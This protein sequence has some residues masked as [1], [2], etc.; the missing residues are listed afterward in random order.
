[1][2]SGSLDVQPHCGSRRSRIRHMIG[3]G[4]APLLARKFC[5][6]KDILPDWAFGLLRS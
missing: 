6:G 3:F 5:M 2:S 4:I 1:M